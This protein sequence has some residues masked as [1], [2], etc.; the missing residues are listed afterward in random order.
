MKKLYTLIAVAITSLGFAQGSETFET[1]QSLTS[2]Y[3]NGSFD[4]ETEGVTVSY[5]H[6][7]NEGIGTAD[8]FAINSSKGIML[9]RI[10]ENSSVSLNIPNGV[11]TFTFQARKA[12]TGGE[13]NRILSIY[14]ND[15]I[16]YTTTT[17]GTSG[18][19][20][21]I[22]TFSAEIN[23]EG[24]VT[25]KIAYPTDTPAGN[26]QITVDN[27]TWT[28]FESTTPEPV[29][30]TA[31]FAS[32]SLTGFTYIEAQ[33]PSTTQSVVLTVADLTAENTLSVVSTNG[34][35]EIV[36]PTALVN[37]ENTIEIRLASGLD[38]G[39]YT[40]SVQ[41]TLGDEILDTIT[42]TGEVTDAP[43]SNVS[44][45]IE[46]LRI[47]PNP[48]NDVVTISTNSSA[49]KSVQIFDISGKQVINVDTD[50]TI[51]VSTLSKGIYVVKIV[52]EGKT[53]TSKLVIK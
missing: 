43:L 18:N 29:E 13:N 45:D 20:T 42:L 23:A 31:T 30:P 21:T 41:V 35:F 49:V 25:I 22:H 11:G 36:N 37:G 9:R 44:N 28:A 47:F 34:N 32:E 52:E 8:D 6:S 16:A 46:G 24:P 17:F 19:D 48:A 26:K 14:V 39:V 4:G 15:V 1:Q 27:I 53:S 7:R 40:G 3:L 12:F 2:A 10:N 5:V 33:G 50:S 51:N 38:A